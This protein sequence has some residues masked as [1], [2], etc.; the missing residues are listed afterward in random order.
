MMPLP[1][2]SSRGSQSNRILLVELGSDAGT[3]RQAVQA[4]EGEREG[5]A[6]N[7]EMVI[8]ST[9]M[10]FV[11]ILLYWL[12]FLSL[13]YLAGILGQR[14][15]AVC[16]AVCISFAVLADLLENHS[17]LV[18]MQVRTFTD[19]VAVD[20]SEYLASGNGLFFFLACFAAG[21]G[22]RVE[23]SHVR[24]ATDL[25]RRLYRRRFV[26][27]PRACRGLAFRWTSPRR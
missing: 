7:T 21:S 23:P 13:A 8:R 9:Y 25:R 10:D 2:L 6:Q 24:Y 27:A 20:I 19:A 22:W 17:I 5:M 18:A 15:L 11:F 14:F 4:D 16:S 1:T 26:R 3:L 12:T